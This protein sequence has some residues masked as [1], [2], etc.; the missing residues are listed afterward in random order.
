MKIIINIGETNE[1]KKSTQMHI[2]QKK[3]SLLVAFFERTSQ[4]KKIK[5]TDLTQ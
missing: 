4:Q 3:S 1:I 5:Y 2:K